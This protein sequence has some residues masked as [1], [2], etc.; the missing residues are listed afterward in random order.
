MVLGRRPAGRTRSELVGP[1]SLRP[2]PS[3]GGKLAR[4]RP[5]LARRHPLSRNTLRKKQLEQVLVLLDLE[6]KFVSQLGLIILIAMFL[7]TYFDNSSYLFP[8]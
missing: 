2:R 8:F 6:P 4:R 5:P 3:V 7:L 1:R